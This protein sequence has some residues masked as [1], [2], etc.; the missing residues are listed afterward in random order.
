MQSSVRSQTR[1]C[2]CACSWTSPTTQQHLRYAGAFN[3]CTGSRTVRTSVQAYKPG[4]REL[5]VSERSAQW[6]CSISTANN[7]MAT[8]IR[9]LQ[10]QY[11]FRAAAKYHRHSIVVRAAPW[12]PTMDDVDRCEENSARTTALGLAVVIMCGLGP[13]TIGRHWWF[14]ATFLPHPYN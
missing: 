9:P 12:R 13:L 11:L 3:A 8:T 14:D 2:R 1:S 7:R 4:G 6:P 5:S 10:P